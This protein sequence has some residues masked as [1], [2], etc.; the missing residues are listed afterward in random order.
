MYIYNPNVSRISVNCLCYQ[1]F[2]IN[3]TNFSELHGHVK[4]LFIISVAFHFCTFLLLFDVF[5]RFH[6]TCR[7]TRC[8]HIV[9]QVFVMC[10][11]REKYINLPGIADSSKKDLQSKKQNKKENAW[12]NF[13]RS[14][15]TR[16]APCCKVVLLPLSGRCFISLLRC[17]RL[18]DM[19]SFPSS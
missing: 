7:R 14:W 4:S 3:N 11:F 8:T 9:F 10:T 6:A 13:L 1:I 2:L 17:L 12:E 19:A 18:E 5:A 15:K 16:G